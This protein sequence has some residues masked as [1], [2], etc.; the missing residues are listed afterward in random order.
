MN[1]KQRQKYIN[2][3]ALRV[4]RSNSLGDVLAAT[5]VANALIEKGHGVV[6]EC[7]ENCHPI[8]RR[9]SMIQHFTG[10]PPAAPNVNLDGAYEKDPLRTT[11]RMPAIFIECAN[12]QLSAHGIELPILENYA[13]KIYSIESE[14]LAL[15]ERI[16]HVPGPWVMVAPRS[17]SFANKTVPDEVWKQFA[18]QLAG[19]SLFWLGSHGAA[20]KGFIDLNCRDVDDLIEYLALADVVVTAETGPMHIAAA[21]GRQVFAIKQAVDPAWALSDQRDFTVIDGTT[22]QCL[23]CQ[24]ARCHIASPPPCQE[25]SPSH[26]AAVVEKRIS[27]QLNNSVSAVIAVYKP[28]IERLNKCLDHVLPQVDEV[29]I[30]Y[31]Y[32]TP[33]LAGMREHV[34]IKTALL[35]SRRTGFGRKANCGA[36]HSNGEYLLFL[37]DDVFLNPDVVKHL[38]EVISADGVGAV[39]HTLRYPDGPI[40][41]AGKYRPQGAHGFG[42]IDY[43]KDK[44]RFGG[45]VEQESFCGASI[46]IRRAA[47]YEADAFDE[48]YFLYSEDDDLAMKMRKAGWKIMFTPLV[49]AIHEEHQTTKLTPEWRERMDESNRKFAQK[50]SKYFADNPNPHVLGQ[51]K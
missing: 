46:L 26:I 51:F 6:F 37:N 31:D 19:A 12:R 1:P 8:L 14:R 34:K 40:Q 3:K 2:R 29:V 48:R 36:R 43:R 21:L 24:Q 18:G 45:P 16:E 13:P 27:F 49:S 22:L 4:R 25:V 9:H 5:C 32:D 42:H 35:K 30:C 50:W 23:N 17:N 28:N 7:R 33:S 20:P 44:S 10:V 38:T 15:L 41:Y 11:K 47:F 39:S